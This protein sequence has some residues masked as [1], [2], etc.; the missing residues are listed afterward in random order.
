MMS[1]KYGIILSRHSS[2]DSVFI[3]LAVVIIF[4]IFV[5]QKNNLFLLVDNNFPVLFLTQKDF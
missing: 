4:N 3:S 2:N 1:F 5:T